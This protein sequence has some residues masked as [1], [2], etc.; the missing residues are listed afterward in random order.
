VKD[1]Y[2]LGKQIKLTLEGERARIIC[3]LKLL[4][5]AFSVSDIYAIV[6]KVGR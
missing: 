6:A 4:A 5:N 1:I 2:V 3:L